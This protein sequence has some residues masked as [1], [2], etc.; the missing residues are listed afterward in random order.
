MPCQCPPGAVAQGRRRRRWWHA[1]ITFFLLALQYATGSKNAPMPAAVRD[2]DVNDDR[3]LVHFL[4]AGVD[5]DVVSMRQLP[6]WFEIKSLIGTEAVLLGLDT[7]EDFR[8]KV[9]PLRRMIGSAGM[10][11]SGT[12]LVS[13]TSLVVAVAKK[14][15]HVPFQMH[16]SRLPYSAIWDRRDGGAFVLI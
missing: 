11:N 6:T 2:H 4:W 9:P 1:V 8:K 15:I 7:C 12:N 3:V 5:L 16:F 13:W 14:N 10:F